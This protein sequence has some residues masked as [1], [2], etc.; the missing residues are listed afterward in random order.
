MHAHYTRT[1]ADG[2]ARFEVRPMPYPMPARAAWVWWLGLMMV[3]GGIP[4]LIFLVGALF[5]AFG[6]WAM[7]SARTLR[8]RYAREAALRQPVTISVDGTHLATSTGTRIALVDLAEL[9]AMNDE[10]SATGAPAHASSAGE[11]FQ[12]VNAR[13]IAQALHD[14]SWSVRARLRGDAR[15][16]TLVHGLDRR[17]ADALVSDLG[18][19][20][21]G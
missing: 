5:I 3:L 16:A 7:W 14:A 21:A 13:R 15:T 19:D 20:V 1:V 12:Q 10:H 9:V 6:A 4:L 18:A 2:I 8:Q 11:A 17:T